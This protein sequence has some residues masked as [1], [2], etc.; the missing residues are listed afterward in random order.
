MNKLYIPFAVTLPL[1]LNLTACTKTESANPDMPHAVVTMRDGKTV[2]GTVISTTP[3]GITL[4]P[5]SGGT[6][7]IPMKEVKS[8]V[9]GDLMFNLGI[10]IAIHSWEST[11]RLAHLLLPIAVRLPARTA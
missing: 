3:T 2:S 6:R 9:Y 11:Q 10:P 5:D 1:L 8:V 4:N 7:D